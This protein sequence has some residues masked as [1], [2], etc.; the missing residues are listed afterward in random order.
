[1][2][3]FYMFGQAY[4]EG[5]YNTGTYSCTAQEQAQG[6]C[7]PAAPGG[8]SGST[9]SGTGAGTGTASGTGSLVDTGVGI[10]FAVTLACLLV[11]GALVIRFIRRPRIATQE[12]ATGQP[13]VI[14]D[15]T[16]K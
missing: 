10:A 14:D 4:G 5:A 16:E 12:V 7:D 13:H 11:F 9:G 2:K 3:Q 6:L 1:M 15:S 8:G